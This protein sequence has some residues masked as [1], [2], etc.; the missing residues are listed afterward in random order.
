MW[1]ATSFVGNFGAG[2]LAR[3]WTG[4]AKP[5]FFLMIAAVAIAAGMV[6]WSFDRPL[7]AALRSRQ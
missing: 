6:I 5:D 2:Y 4:I 7:R 1:L 3:F